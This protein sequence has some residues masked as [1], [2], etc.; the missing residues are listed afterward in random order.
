[1]YR[2]IA[3]ALQLTLITFPL[4]ANPVRAQNQ[5]LTEVQWRTGNAKV[6]NLIQQLTPQEKISLVHGAVAPGSLELT[7]DPSSQI[8]AGYVASVPRLGIPAIRLTDGEA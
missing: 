5:N 6:D 2:L 8:Q 4:Y 3:F 1:M 7:A